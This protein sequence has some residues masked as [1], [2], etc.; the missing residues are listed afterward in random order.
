MRKRRMIIE[1]SS[2]VHW[3][4]QKRKLVCNPDTSKDFSSHRRFRT[5]KQAM[6]VLMSLPLEAKA[7][8]KYVALYPK[9]RIIYYVQPGNEDVFEQIT[10]TPHC[11]ASR[12]GIPNPS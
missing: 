7:Y 10:G 3:W 9:Y 6:Q 5:K 1:I 4:W 8:L 2:T 12:G 11:I